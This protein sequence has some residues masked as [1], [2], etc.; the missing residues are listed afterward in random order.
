MRWTRRHTFCAPRVIEQRKRP[1][2]GLGQ[3]QERLIRIVKSQQSACIPSLRLFTRIDAI[4]IAPEKSRRSQQHRS[5]RL[6]DNTVRDGASGRGQRQSSRNSSELAFGFVPLAEKRR[7]D[8][9]IYSPM[10]A[11]EPKTTGNRDAHLSYC[12]Q[13]CELQLVDKEP[14]DEGEHADEQRRKNSV[15]QGAIR[16][17]AHVDD[18]VSN[19]GVCYGEGYDHHC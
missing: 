7:V 4:P 18:T 15:H 8:Q 16:D 12:A 11:V 9:R 1:T 2:L 14:V 10:Q 6:I 3:H 17:E 5:N 19:D 13:S